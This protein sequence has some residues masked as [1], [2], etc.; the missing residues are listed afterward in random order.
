MNKPATDA[1]RARQLLAA[2]GGEADDFFKIWPTDKT[3]YFSSD[4]ESFVAYAV[5]L[6]IAVCLGDPV[7]D[8]TSIKKLLVEFKDFCRSKHLIICFIQATDK[9]IK[10][11]QTSNLKSLLIGADAVIDLKQFYATTIHDKYFR[12]LVNRS[13]KL[14]VSLDS[15]SPPHSKKLISELKVV[16]DSWGS[17]PHRKE[18]SFLTGRFDNDY[19][20][21][22]DLYLLRDKD[23]K[24]QAFANGLPDYKPGVITVDLM[25]HRADAP[26]NCIDFLFI[27]LLSVKKTDGYSYFNLGI[28][29]LDAKP[30]IK[31]PAEKLLNRAYRLSNSFIGF[32]GLHHFK[33]KYKPNWEPRYIF[34]QKGLG[35]LMRMGLAVLLLLKG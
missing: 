33:A 2:Y 17:L 24:A 23:G 4:N 32:N 6:R 31:S 9:Y 15:Y 5:K 1:E 7:G 25:R 18:W 29:P 34:Y 22:V 14:G 20:N 8:K 11:Y 3:F 21:R 10:D 26:P 19:L 12:N 35:R 13:D 27:K 28:S 16:S 30:F